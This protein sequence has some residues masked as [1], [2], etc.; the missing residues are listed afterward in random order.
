MYG[1]DVYIVVYSQGG[2]MKSRNH[3][4]GLI[5]VVI[6]AYNAEKTIEKAIQSAI[7]QSY[8]DIEVIIVDDCSQDG[9][10][11]IVNAYAKKDSRIKVFQNQ[12]NRGAAFSR[13]R[14][15]KEARGE[16]IAFL[17]SDDKWDLLKLE[18]QSDILKKNPSCPLCFTGS[19][20]ENKRG[21]RCS[22]MLSVP[23]QMNYHDLLKQNLISC[24]S[25]LVKKEALMEFPMQSDPM[26]HEDL[27]TWL[28]ILKGGSEAVGVDEPLLIY[29][30]SSQSKSGNKLRAAR[31]QW[32]TYQ[33]VG[34]GYLKSIRYFLIYAWRNIKKYI[35]IL[36]DFERVNS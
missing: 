21:T 4:I 3:S 12:T 9:T 17:D 10:V 28:K 14:G 15:V 6:P 31:M 33:V 26:I 2:K 7:A 29:R 13:N 22:Y 25:V 34:I 18:K 27:A 32:K 35:R 36:S 19:A 30:I 20:F 24:S 1:K 11:K 16:W 5:S 23:K 8:S